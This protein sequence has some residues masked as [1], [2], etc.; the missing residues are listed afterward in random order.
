[1]R[2]W[3]ATN[4]ACESSLQTCVCVIEKDEGEN[5][6]ARKNNDTHKCEEHD[7]CTLSW[8]L[9]SARAMERL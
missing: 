8:P 6:R 5:G 4:T 7:L 3:T 9:A 1:M 2:T